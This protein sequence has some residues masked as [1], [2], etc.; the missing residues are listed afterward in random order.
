VTE[1]ISNGVR[2][3]H[4]TLELVLTFDGRCL[5]LSIADGDPRTP[6][7]RAREQ[8][9]VGGW[10]LALID[11]LS[12]EWGTDVDDGRGKTVW[13]EIDITQLEREP[14]AGVRAMSPRPGYL[15]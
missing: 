7:A 9:M 10:G 15:S 2:H 6:V 14:G 13:L 1:L 8:L 4:T 11:S 12:T 5:R 3:A